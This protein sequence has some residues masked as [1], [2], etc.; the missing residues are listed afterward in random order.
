[1]YSEALL[2]VLFIAPWLTQERAISLIGLLTLHFCAVAFVS[3][4]SVTLG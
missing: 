2:E 1:M 3:H 4:I